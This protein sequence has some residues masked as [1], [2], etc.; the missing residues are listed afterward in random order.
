M[1]TVTIAGVTKITIASQVP[2]YYDG[3]YTRKDTVETFSLQNGQLF[4]S[5]TMWKTHPTSIYLS[6]DSIV[7]L[8][9]GA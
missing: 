7:S 5:R 1:V 8:E 3:N 2:I 9:L 4:A 6:G